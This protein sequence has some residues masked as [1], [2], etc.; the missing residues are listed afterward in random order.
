MDMNM[1][2]RDWKREQL[3]DA[4]DDIGVVLSARKVA[5]RHGLDR[6]DDVE[7]DEMMLD[8]MDELHRRDECSMI[9]IFERSVF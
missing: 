1:D 8:I 7:L 9:D 3:E 2:L 5:R 6:L 4:L